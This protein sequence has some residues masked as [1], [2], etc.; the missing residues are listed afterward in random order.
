M[1]KVLAKI[2]LFFMGWKIKGNIP[3]GLKKCVIVAAPHTSNSDFFIGRL[4]FYILGLKQVHFFIKR[5]AF[6]FPFKKLL[7]NAGGIPVD[8]ANSSNLVIDIVERFKKE[9]TFY[10]VIT[11]EGTRKKTNRWKMGFYHIAKEANVP[12]ALAYVDYK[13]KEGGIA[14]LVEAKDEKPVKEEVFSFYKTIHAKYPE[15]FNLSQ[16]VMQKPADS[17]TVRELTNQYCCRK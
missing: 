4:A 6:K 17:K 2:I 12:I 5:E 7:L 11:P 15:K 16:S 1:K 10:L 3:S 8:R 9:D 13:K 14:K